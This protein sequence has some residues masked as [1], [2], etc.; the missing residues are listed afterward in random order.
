MPMK[1]LEFEPQKRAMTQNVIGSQK[2]ALHVSPFAVVKVATF[3]SQVLSPDASSLQS[4]LSYRLSWCHVDVDLCKEHRI[5]IPIPLS[6]IPIN[7][8]R[9]ALQSSTSSAY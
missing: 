4:S 2:D 1:T 8:Q 7:A 6:I 3:S 9:L 5:K